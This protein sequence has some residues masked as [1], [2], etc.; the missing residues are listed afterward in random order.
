MGE[1]DTSEYFID[2]NEADVYL[3]IYVR[4]FRKAQDDRFKQAAN[5]VISHGL[6]SGPKGGLLKAAKLL[7]DKV[8]NSVKEQTRSY[9]LKI[10]AEDNITLFRWMQAKAAFNEWVDNWILTPS[11]GMH[12]TTCVEHRV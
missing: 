9:Q 8:Y 7:G 12:G 2:K 11:A 6:M 4:E 10:T 5:P 1:W 3:P